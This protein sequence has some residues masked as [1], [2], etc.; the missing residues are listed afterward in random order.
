MKLNVQ[1]S[2]LSN[3]SPWIFSSC[4][5]NAHTGFQASEWVKLLDL[6]HSLSHDEALLLCPQSDSEWVAWVPNFGEVVLHV[7]Q[8][9]AQNEE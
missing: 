5:T 4:V 9:R 7:S 6:P 3:K 2:T 1:N 8:F